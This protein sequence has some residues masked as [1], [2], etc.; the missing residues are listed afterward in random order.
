MD[1][2][3]LH[4]IASSALLHSIRPLSE[5]TL[6]YVYVAP[7]F[8]DP[9]TRKLVE[10][11]K[12]DAPELCDRNARSNFRYGRD[13]LRKEIAHGDDTEFPGM[14]IS[15]VGKRPFVVRCRNYDPETNELYI[16]VDSDLDMAF[17]LEVSL[18]IAKV[19]EALAALPGHLTHCKMP[20]EG[21]VNGPIETSFWTYCS[22]TLNPG[23]GRG[24]SLT[25]TL[26]TD[27]EHPGRVTLEVR[28]A[29]CPEFGFFIAFTPNTLSM[30]CSMLHP[31]TDPV[32]LESFKKMA[33]V[34]NAPE[35][36]HAMTEAGL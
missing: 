16:R 11:G 36:A 6:P 28:A 1:V 35:V 9:S 30:A 32:Q 34:L 5:G 26:H 27:R 20:C 14:S 19:E 4:K 24:R 22:Y 21:R 23:V 2:P 8:L 29:H 10:E 17:W 15:A 18:S 3:T 33:I 12:W 31:D 25:A 13:S 7:L